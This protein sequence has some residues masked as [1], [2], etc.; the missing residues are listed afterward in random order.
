MP[1]RDELMDE[2]R[3]DENG[4]ARDKTFHGL[5]KILLNFEATCVE[6]P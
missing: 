1:A 4:R 2:V 6:I 3:A 5:Q